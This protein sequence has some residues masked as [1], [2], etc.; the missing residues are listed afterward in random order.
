[1]AYQDAS[2]D[3]NGYLD[4]TVNG[5]EIPGS[6][7]ELHGTLS[8]V[9]TADKYI[10]TGHINFDGTLSSTIQTIMYKDAYASMYGFLTADIANANSFSFC[11]DIVADMVTQEITVNDCKIGHNME[12]ERYRGDTY[13]VK[14]TLSRNG[15]FDATGIT[16]KMSVKIGESA[17]ETIDGNI[18]DTANGVVEF[19]LPTTITDVTGSGVFDIQGDDG[20]IY[21]YTKGTI[22]IIQDVTP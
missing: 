11:A 7:I 17:V 2:A 20:Y 12:L 1:M 6:L 15:N 5:E 10:G 16:F 14:A 8:S 4:S 18:L 9:V 3:L 13:P 21:T 19:I 22:N